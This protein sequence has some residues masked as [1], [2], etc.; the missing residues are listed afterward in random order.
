MKL[1]SFRIYNYKSIVDSGECRLLENDNITVLAGQNESGKSSILQALRDYSNNEISD[2]VKRLD[3]D[4][5]SISCTY[6]I[7]KD[8]MEQVINNLL[9][10]YICK[11]WLI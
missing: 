3:S 5:P 7:D 2:E 8:E 9:N 4:L 10:K 1:K 11:L 6:I